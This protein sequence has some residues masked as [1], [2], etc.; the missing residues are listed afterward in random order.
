[1][2]FPGRAVTSLRD[3]ARSGLAGARR[4]ARDDR[5]QDLIEYALLLGFVGLALVGSG[6]RIPLF[7]PAGRALTPP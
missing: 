1:M 6:V 2:W 5:G 4:F 7:H 3:G